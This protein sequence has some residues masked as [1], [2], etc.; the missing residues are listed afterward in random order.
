LGQIVRSKKYGTHWRIIE[1]KEV[2]QNT[3]D[4]PETGEPRSLIRFHRLRCSERFRY[5]L[6][7]AIFCAEIG[8]DQGKNCSI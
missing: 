1:K 6:S 5:S 3:N 4:D 2:W 7:R 8:A